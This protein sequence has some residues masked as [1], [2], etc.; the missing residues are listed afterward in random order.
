MTVADFDIMMVHLRGT[1]L[2]VR[3]AFPAADLSSYII[4]SVI[5]VSR[6]GRCT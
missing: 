1:R 4:G 3:V 6:G 2:G 5:E